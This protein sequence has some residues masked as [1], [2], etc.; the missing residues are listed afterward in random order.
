MPV[1]R[2]TWIVATYHDVVTLLSD[3][4]DSSGSL[5]SARAD[6]NIGIIDS[7]RNQPHQ[8]WNFP[9]FVTFFWLHGVFGISL[10]NWPINNLMKLVDFLILGGTW[11]RPQQ[12]RAYG[13]WYQC[14]ETTVRD[15]GFGTCNNGTR[16]T[17]L[18]G[19]HW[20]T[21]LLFFLRQQWLWTSLKL[22]LPEKI[23]ATPWSWYGFC[24]RNVELEYM[25]HKPDIN[26]ESPGDWMA[27]L[28]NCD[29][30]M[31]ERSCW[32]RLGGEV[33]RATY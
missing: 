3:S 24:W 32:E 33:Y 9:T 19:A 21:D 22:S 8:N 25:G 12:H 29:L 13:W 15:L 5:W 4:S 23:A 6:G 16:D 27:C 20:G 1:S 2:V 18:N 30:C 28:G 26:S 17:D 10:L 7:L 31:P 14:L 11:S